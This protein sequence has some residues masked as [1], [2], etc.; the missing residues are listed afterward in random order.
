MLP[1]FTRNP[2]CAAA[3]A[4]VAAC[5]APAAASA[6]TNVHITP[7][8][9]GP[10]SVTFGG[11]DAYTCAGPADDR[12]PAKTCPSIDR[13]G[14]GSYTY[15][16]IQLF[17]KAPEK[18]GVEFV[19]WDN[20]ASVSAGFICQYSGL[21]LNVTAAPTAVFDDKGGP[22]ITVTPT[23]STT[24]ERTIAFGI[25][26]DEPAGIECRID[27]QAFA[28]CGAGKTATLAEGAHTLDVRATDGSGNLSTS[29]VP[30]TIVD[31]A[32]GGGPSGAS[33]SRS[34]QFA[35]SSGAGAGTTFECSLDD[36]AFAP[37]GA[38]P[39]YTGLSEGPHTFKA[40]AKNGSAYDAIAAQRT[41]TVDTVAP[42]TTLDASSGP[43]DGSV[44]T[45]TTES[46]AFAGAGADRF[47]CRIDGGAYEPCASPR[48]VSGL[49]PG[50]HTFEVRGVDNAGNVDATPETRAWTTQ[51]DD[52]GDGYDATKDCDDANPARHPGAREIADNGADEDCDGA[53]AVDLDRDGDGIPRPADC[54]DGNGA[55]RPGAA[56][57]PANKVDE[58]CDGKDARLVQIPFTLRYD[59][60]V[61][62]AKAT[63]LN[64]FAVNG[65]PSGS[66]VE[67]S[68]VK[69][70]KKARKLVK[71]NAK[72][73]LAIKPL[74]KTSVKAGAKI[75]V[76]VSKPGMVT[77]VRTLK[78]N[79]RKAPTLTVTCIAPGARTAKAC[80]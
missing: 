44:T 65:L 35:L 1:R 13:A 69:C 16:F 19:R 7:S 79:A 46:F 68:C 21:D 66:K 72:G 39:A 70:P 48:A 14:T 60:A 38:A 42:H 20:C 67:I 25:E 32:I 22:G 26:T 4:A 40:R 24:S 33:T 27:A 61:Y 58:D 37:C 74:S 75:V 52:D 43:R 30:F 2:L 49:Q 77:T 8:V 17:A 6:A 53:D 10:G 64:M 78:I 73:L 31:T 59:A 23:H 50:R 15:T 5:A 36:A 29:A 57:V 34:A 28:G 51:R 56:D 3:I 54:N 63:K 11:D 12:A 71:K 80:A 62:G 55:I 9:A 41:W 18:G 45:N 47:E 76:K